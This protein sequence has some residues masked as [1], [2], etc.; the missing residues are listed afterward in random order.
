LGSPLGPLFAIVFMSYF[1][2]TQRRDEENGKR[3]VDDV[4]ATFDKEEDSEILLNFLN[5]QHPNIK[6]TLER[7]ENNQIAFLNTCVIRS[8]T[9]YRT[10]QYRKKTF[11]GVYF[12]WTS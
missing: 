5:D 11:T 10:A 2:E 1:G 9:R 8:R 3:Y 7:E 6:F 12:N 4:F